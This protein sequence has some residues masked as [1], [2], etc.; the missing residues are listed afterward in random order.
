MWLWVTDVTGMTNV[1]ICVNIRGRELFLW[2]VTSVSWYSKMGA[3]MGLAKPIVNQINKSNNNYLARRFQMG[4][5]ISSPPSAPV[6]TARPLQMIIQMQ[7]QYLTLH[8][9]SMKIKVPM[10]LSSRIMHN[11]MKGNDVYKLSSIFF[12]NTL[13]YKKTMFWQ[14]FIGNLSSTFL[15]F[16]IEKKYD[17]WIHLS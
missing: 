1:V 2:C 8:V 15:S 6:H 13:K 7:R 10:S 16:F 9:C 4:R 17:L 5:E 14:F 3:Q 12:F 11:S